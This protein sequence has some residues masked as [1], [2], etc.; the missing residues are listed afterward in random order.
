M[1]KSEKNRVDATQREERRH[2]KCLLDDY[3][4]NNF[5]KKSQVEISWCRNLNKKCIY[6]KHKKRKTQHE[7][8]I[9]RRIAWIIPPPISLS[10]FKLTHSM[11]L[12][13]LNK[14]ININFRSAWFCRNKFSWQIYCKTI[15][16]QKKYYASH[17]VIVSTRKDILLCAPLLP[18]LAKF[19]Y[20]QGIYFIAFCLNNLF[21]ALDFY[22]L[23]NLINSTVTRVTCTLMYLWCIQAYISIIKYFRLAFAIASIWVHFEQDDD[24]SLNKIFRTHC[25]L[26]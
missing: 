17:S 1:E 24:S 3:K 2:C 6:I 4:L 12:N 20:V 14:Q 8:L 21:N 16:Q 13:C 11:I 18:N 25:K 19:F 9:W 10:L 26:H 23:L 5:S 22:Y 7:F 15:L